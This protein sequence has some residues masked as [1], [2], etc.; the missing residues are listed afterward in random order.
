MKLLLNITDNL[1]VVAHDQTCFC[2]KNE[3]SSISDVLSQ[4]KTLLH[5]VC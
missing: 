5:T 4:L 1:E 3:V 2:Q